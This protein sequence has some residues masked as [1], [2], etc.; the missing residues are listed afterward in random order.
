MGVEFGELDDELDAVDYPVSLSELLDAHGDAELDLKGEK[1]SLAE[2][3]A[4]LESD[5][6]ESADEVRQ[7]VLNMV[8]SE[9]IGRERYTDRGVGALD[10]GAGESADESF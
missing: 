1:R 10:E 3:L 8:D 6:F 9:A 2:L 4:P 7:S 5:T